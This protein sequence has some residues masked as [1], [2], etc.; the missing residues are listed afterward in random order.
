[1]KNAKTMKILIAFGVMLFMTAMFVPR[2]TDAQT[3]EVVAAIL[4]AE[5]IYKSIDEECDE[6]RP[7][8]GYQVCKGGQCVSGKCITL[9]S[10]CDDE[11]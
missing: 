6:N 9:R 8:G 4:A 11:C 2:Q 10:R 5:K 1:M 3:G 7:D